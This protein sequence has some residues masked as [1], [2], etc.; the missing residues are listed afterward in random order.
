MCTG[1]TQIGL[2]SATEGMAQAS[3]LTPSLLTPGQADRLLVLRISTSSAHR[4]VGRDGAVPSDI[5][6][7]GRCGGNAVVEVGRACGPA[8]STEGT[9]RANEAMDWRVAW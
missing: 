1:L 8:S 3:L 6:C 7:M 5:A 4:K 2:K 9:R